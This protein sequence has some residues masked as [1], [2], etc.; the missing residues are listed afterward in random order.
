VSS[1]WQEVNGLITSPQD[2]LEEISARHSLRWTLPLGVAGYYW[3]TLPL[4][5][6]LLGPI[7]G[8]AAYL[9]ANVLVALGWMVLLTG[10]IHLATRLLG[11][12]RGRWRD[13]L[14]LWG[15]TQIPGIALIVLSAVF[16]TTA[17]H[18]WRHTAGLAWFAPALALVAVLFF[19]KLILQYQAIRVCYGLA[20]A[21]LLGVI[22]L[23]LILY[24]LVVWAEFSLV[25]D[26]G[27]VGPAAWQA[28]S[29]AL[30]PEITPRA[31]V[32][33]A[34]DRLVYRVR[35]PRRGEVVGF[36][37][38]GWTD[39][40]ASVLLRDR[41]RFLGRVVGV[42]GDEIEVRQGQLNLN[43]RPADEPYREGRGEVDVGPTRLL[44]DQ[45]FVLGDNRD[46][47]LAAYHGGLLTGRDL[48]GRLTEVG[49][50]RWVYLDRASRC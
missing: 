43:G 6:V 23:A 14:V 8:P 18:G 13:L 1:I 37:P 20:T 49:W 7:A 26:R 45:Y 16:L 31:H 30:C 34:F 28:M 39:S 9:V 36:V 50:V 25:D 33:L 11:H 41:R 32:P 21:R 46:V 5:E 44:A 2:G 24:N 12:R 4:S 48:R 10:L 17:P 40:P 29:S 35:A 27:R 38:S 22:G 19:W 42:P 15:Y 47:P 3:R